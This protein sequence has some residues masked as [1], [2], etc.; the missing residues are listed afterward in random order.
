[1]SAQLTN[2][3]HHQ[4]SSHSQ[5]SL[6]PTVLIR[7]SSSL[8]SPFKYTMHSAI[9][10]LALLA[11][12]PLASARFS[13]APLRARADDC[14]P[15]PKPGEGVTVTVTQP[16]ATNAP[17][18]V[19][20]IQTAPAPAA[21]TVTVTHTAAVQQPAVTVTVRPQPANPAPNAVPNSVPNSVANANK[22]PVT[23]SIRPLTS[24]QPDRL[25]VTKTVTADQ[26]QQP[27]Q[28]EGP[29]TVTV[30]VGASSS[31]PPPPKQAP[32]TIT[33]RPLPSESPSRPNEPETVT[34]TVGN[35]PE[36]SKQPITVS[37][38]NNEVVTKTATPGNNASDTPNSNNQPVT[39][40]IK[41]EDPA[42]NPP[43]S[44]PSNEGASSR[45][46]VT[47]SIK[48]P[49]DVTQTMAPVTVTAAPVMS[50]VWRNSTETQFQTMTRTVGHGGGD[51]IEIIIINI[52]TGESICKKKDSGEPCHHQPPP[53]VTG[54]PCPEV[55]NI[56]STATAF[57]TVRITVS[58][59]PNRNATASATNG[60]AKPSGPVT[61]AIRPAPVRSRW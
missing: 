31:A 9:A 6:D 61:I 50:T 26:Q 36:P 8:N 52:N 29:E 42:T 56:T 37:I 44:A 4:L 24:Q 53:M 51:N 49:Q 58:G 57:N 21:Q 38:K 35:E 25:V 14:C 7:L 27:P 60:G 47:I 43:S 20:V 1:M 45:Q 40:S 16:A 41:K 30:T 22:Q 13:F 2:S 48:N 55:R 28:L 19:T 54:S 18:T 3:S 17:T 10:T 39:V 11:A 15:C 12:A 23:I 32:V 46:P 34:M 33:V 59:Q 5:S